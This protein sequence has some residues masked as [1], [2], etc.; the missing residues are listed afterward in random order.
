VGLRAPGLRSDVGD[1]LFDRLDLRAEVVHPAHGII[2]MELR[3]IGTAVIVQ[4][5]PPI[6]AQIALGA[7]M[8]RHVH[9]ASRTAQ[10]AAPTIG[11]FAPVAIQSG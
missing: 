9:L 6:E 5:G 2:M 8:D 1:R 10:A 3:V 11:R 4:L 7:L